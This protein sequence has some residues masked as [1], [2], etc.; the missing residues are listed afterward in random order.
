MLALT[1]KDIMTKD[2]VTVKA[3]T[4]LVDVAKILT[5]HKFN[6]LPVIDDNGILAGIVTEYS[7]IS[8]QSGI[9]LPT[10]QAVLGNLPVFSKDKSEFTEEIAAVT[11]LT[12]RDVMNNDP[13]TLSSTATYEEVVRA[14]QD[15]HGVNPIPVIDPQ[16]KLVGVVSRYDVLKPLSH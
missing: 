15:H 13:L 7:L 11:K 16:R 12:A 4:P 2:P 8:S 14:F 1:I 3:A 5:E 9:H 6:G 10:L